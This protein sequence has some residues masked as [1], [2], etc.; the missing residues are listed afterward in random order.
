MTALKVC[1]LA[2]F[3]SPAFVSFPEQYNGTL[4]L[5]HYLEL[6]MTLSRGDLKIS[7]TQ[8]SSF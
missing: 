4:A 7:G 1:R 8:G 5:L 2:C 6:I 3:L